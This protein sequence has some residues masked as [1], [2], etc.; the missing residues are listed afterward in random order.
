LDE[1]SYAAAITAVGLVLLNMNDWLELEAE[2]GARKRSHQLTT[3]IRPNDW[4]Y[5][6]L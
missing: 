4:I 2:K 3:T 5:D 6:C 1:A